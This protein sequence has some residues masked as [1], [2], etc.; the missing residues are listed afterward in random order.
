MLDVVP[1]E[2]D[3]GECPSG[4]GGGNCLKSSLE[5]AAASNEGGGGNKPGNTNSACSH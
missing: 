4:E 5:I 1:S 3:V 2:N